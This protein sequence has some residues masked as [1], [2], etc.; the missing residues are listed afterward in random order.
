MKYQKER[1]GARKK[2]YS[3]ID[4]TIDSYPKLL[5]FGIRSKSE[6]SSISPSER[7]ELFKLQT[8][9]AKKV[10]KSE[11]EIRAGLKPTQEQELKRIREEGIERQLEVDKEERRAKISL[12]KKKV[13]GI[14][15]SA[16]NLLTSRGQHTILRKP[17]AKLPSTDPKKFITKGMGK[18]SLVREGRTG[19]FNEEMMEETKWLS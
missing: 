1:S 13:E 18:Q 2:T 3:Q 9:Q 14:G 7:K 11:A 6:A 8:S 19:F 4:K 17:T 16:M 12:A 10:A 5:S 15:K